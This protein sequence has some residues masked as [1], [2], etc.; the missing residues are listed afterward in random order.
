MNRIRDYWDRQPCGILH[1]P[2]KMG[3][4][5]YFR[6]LT[7]R[8]Y[9]VQPHIIEF[10][11]FERWQDKSVL[12]IG[13]GIGTDAEQFARA[14]ARYTGIDLSLVSIKVARQR[15]KLFDLEGE[16]YVGNCEALSKHISL[17]KHDLVYIWG[18]LHHT[19]NPE[20][21]LSQARQYMDNDSE[22]RIMLYAKHSWKSAMI[23]A[24]LDQSE[25]QADCPLSR[26][27]TQE[28]AKALLK[29]YEII[30]LWQ[31]HIFPYQVPAYKEWGYELQP[32][33][34]AMPPMMFRAL[35]KRF[36]WHLMVWA[37][38]K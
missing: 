6:Q 1:S 24:G 22:L 31:D 37:K 26:Q 27:Y 30:H 21:V 15:F 28:E 23:D 2:E 32:W 19:P 38:C 5:E 34:A 16:F 3:S 35:E 9:K 8:R 12:E 4:P 14:G 29:D 36:G 25:A 17:Q 10:A 7:A 33:F 13:C 11:E 18:M 20:K